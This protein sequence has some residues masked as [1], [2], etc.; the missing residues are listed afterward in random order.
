[1]LHESGYAFHTWLQCGLKFMIDMTDS[2][3]PDA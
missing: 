1:M 3:R 2:Y